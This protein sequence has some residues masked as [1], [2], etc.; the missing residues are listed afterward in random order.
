MLDVSGLAFRM[1][2]A[3]AIGLLI[4]AE[5]E[6]RKGEGPSRSAAGI[7]TFAVVSLIGAVAVVIGDWLLPVA[8]VAVAALTTVSYLRSAYDDPGL[9][10]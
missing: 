3:L 1:L 6:R 5:R 7:R 2:S 4:G 10:T 9:T 8:V